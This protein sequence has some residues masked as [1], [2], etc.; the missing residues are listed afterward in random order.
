VTGAYPD[1]VADPQES[2]SWHAETLAVALGRPRDPGAP[3]NPPLV[4][5]STYRDG[6][7]LGYAREGNAGWAALEE[8]VGAL[9][10]GPAVAFGSGVAAAAAVLEDLPV[11]T[12]VVSPIAPYHGITHLLA[13]RAAVGRL[14]VTAVDQT[15]LGAVAA[16]LERAARHA[17]VAVWAE[18]P[19]NPMMD[20]VDLS[21]LA[22]MV[23]AHEGVLIVDN[24]FATPLL[25]RPLLLGADVV[26][27]SGTKLIG[28][29]SDLL[30]G[31]AVGRDLAW[32]GRLVT[33]RHR[34]GN[35][36]GALEAFLALRGVRTLPVRLD[37]AQGTA[38]DL[39]GRLATHPAIARVRYPGL[40]EHPAAQVVAR[41]MAGPGTVLAVE[42][43]GDAD[44]ADR[45]C[46]MVR[47]LV[48]GTSLGGVESLIERRAK[49]EGDRAAGVPETLLRI[50]V[51]LEH[52]DDLWADLDHALTTAAEASGRGWS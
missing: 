18:S 33:S 35:V 31:L 2:W 14:G 21:E 48:P 49:Y 28:G 5:S 38:S 37:R 6:G 47:L 15:D 20:V 4:L 29:H 13:D 24:T 44:L 12:H 3:V 17:P 42:T 9:E 10:G 43:V 46:Q 26:V 41:Q 7:D 34:N 52:V 32:A 19:T 51:G 45:A 40:P 50:S 36:P 8:V 39:A 25:Q 16:T 1:D 23:H 22:T 11:G 30:L 27:H